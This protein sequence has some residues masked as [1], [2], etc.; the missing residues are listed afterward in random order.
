MQIILP[1]SSLTCEEVY[2]VSSGKF[3]F[4]GV[5]FLNRK[6][7][8]LIVVNDS[9]QKVVG[10]YKTKM[11]TIESIEVLLNRIVED[12][13]NRIYRPFGIYCT[14]WI[15]KTNQLRVPAKINKHLGGSNE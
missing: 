4:F 15:S 13:E 8:S 7:L 9:E 3:T 2:Q 12:R 6:K 11:S 5:R 10:T 1:D 14:A